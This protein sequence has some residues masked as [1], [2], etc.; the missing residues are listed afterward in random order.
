MTELWLDQCRA[1]AT[2]YMQQFF[3]HEISIHLGAW[4]LWQVCVFILFLFSANE[5]KKIDASGEKLAF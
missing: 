4:G 2:A 5:R 1:I 3:I